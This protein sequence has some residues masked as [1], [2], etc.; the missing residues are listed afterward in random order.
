MTTDSGP[1]TYRSTELAAELGLNN[2]YIS[3]NG[4]WPEKGAFIKTCSFKELEAFPQ[5]ENKRQ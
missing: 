1:V 5:S 2:L 4:Y 3:F